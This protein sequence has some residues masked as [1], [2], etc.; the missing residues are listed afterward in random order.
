MSAAIPVK[1][2]LQAG[3]TSG[4]A[5]ALQRSFFGTGAAGASVRLVSLLGNLIREHVKLRVEA[6]QRAGL[7]CTAVEAV[8]EDEKRGS[9]Q[10]D[11]DAEA[12]CM[13][14]GLGRLAVE[15]PPDAD[16]AEDGKRPGEEADGRK[17]TANV[18]VHGVRNIRRHSADG[19]TGIVQACVQI[20]RPWRRFR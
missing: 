20:G 17:D 9:L 10:A 13:R 7:V 1:V 12:F 6:G 4:A 18:R 11:E 3:R 19:Y 5:A 15:E 14:G 8:R 2:P 16:G